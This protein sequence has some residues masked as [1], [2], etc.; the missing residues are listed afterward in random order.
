MYLKYF[1]VHDIMNLANYY[2]ANNYQYIQFIILLLVLEAF[3]HFSTPRD[4]IVVKDFK[5]FVNPKR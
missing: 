3:R 2:D 4:K 5:S 1:L